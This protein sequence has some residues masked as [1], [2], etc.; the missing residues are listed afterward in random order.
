MLRTILADI[1]AHANP[2]RRTGWRFWLQVFGKAVF[3]PAVH[4]TI[5]FRLS[6]VLYR[7]LLTRPFAFALRTFSVVWGGT[8]IHPAATIGPGMCIVHS[9]K[10]LIGEGVVIGNNARICHGVSIGGDIGR[11]GASGWPHIGDNVF[12]GMDVIIMGDVKI[13][14]RVRLG[15]QSLVIK[16]VP[17]DAI[18]AA[19][20]ALIKRMG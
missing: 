13:G 11:M 16:D 6:T 10:V 8:E 18:V 12:I 14:D 15:A 20:P 7:H 5:L 3:S 9:Q 19:A 1:A 4:T 17:D 2:V